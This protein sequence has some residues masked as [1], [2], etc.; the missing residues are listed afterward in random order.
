MATQFSMLQIINAALVSQGQ[1][2]VV[3]DDN[4]NEWAL[5]SQNWPLIVEAELEDGA[6]DFVR[7]QHFLQS[8]VDG[9]FGFADAYLV[10]LTAMFVRQLWVETD[11]GTRTS[12]AWSQDGTHV[13]VDAASGVYIEAVE[14]A[15]PDLWGAN[16][17]RGVQ[18]KLEAV[19]LR[20]LKEESGEAARLEEQA[21]MHFDRARTKSSKSRSATEPFRSGRLTASRFARG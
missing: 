11:G 16:F 17:C 10:P 3:E 13:H 15:E 8:R 20:A 18:L 19:I 14:V 1:Y 5:L 9:K 12:I 7:T 4:S 21:E 6:Y 2:S